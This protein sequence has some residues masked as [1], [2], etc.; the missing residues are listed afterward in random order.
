MICFTGSYDL[1][2]MRQMFICT[3]GMLLQC[4]PD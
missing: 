4:L 1:A 3:G 2:E